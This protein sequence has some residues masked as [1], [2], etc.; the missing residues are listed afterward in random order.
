VCVCVCIQIYGI[1]RKG[2]RA[3]PRRHTGVEAE[4]QLFFEAPSPNIFGR[5]SPHQRVRS[6]PL[7]LVGLLLAR[8]PKTHL[9]TTSLE[10]VG[11]SGTRSSLFTSCVVALSLEAV[12][13]RTTSSSPCLI[14]PPTCPLLQVHLLTGNLPD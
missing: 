8:R 3:G 13:L 5:V 9:E 12:T 2:E 6:G 7:F 11:N 10:K 14:C 1:L 4:H